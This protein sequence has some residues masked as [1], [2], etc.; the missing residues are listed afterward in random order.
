[1]SK[2]ANEIIRASLFSSFISVMEAYRANSGGSP[3]VL[4]RDLSAV[5]ANT[6]FDN[7]PEN[8]QKA[9]I[10]SANETFRRLMKEGYVIQPKSTPT[11]GRN[12]DRSKSKRA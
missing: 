11:T 9:L 1:M 8:V 4:V 3:N 5:H 12:N 10:E 6:G 2:S 7:I